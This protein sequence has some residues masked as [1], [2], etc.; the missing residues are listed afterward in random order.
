M[1]ANTNLITKTEKLGAVK[2]RQS[3]W[4]IADQKAT[5]GLTDDDMVITYTKST[6]FGRYLLAIEKA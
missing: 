2:A 4:T 5:A 1:S 3:I 6:P